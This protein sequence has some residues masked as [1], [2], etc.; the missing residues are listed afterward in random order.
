MR[1][2]KTKQPNLEEMVINEDFKPDFDA[3]TEAGHSKES[4]DLVEKLLERNK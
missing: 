1:R 4:R 2:K 3:I